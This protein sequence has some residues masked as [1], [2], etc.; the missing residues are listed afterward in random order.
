MECGDMNKMVICFLSLRSLSGLPMMPAA[1]WLSAYSKVK[2]FSFLST[3]VEKFS[4]LAGDFILSYFPNTRQ[5]AGYL[6]TVRL[7]YSIKFD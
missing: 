5:M 4:G 3:L 6:R 2:S 7:D 1:V